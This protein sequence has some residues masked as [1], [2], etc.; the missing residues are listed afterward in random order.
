[1]HDEGGV[2][3]SAWRGVCVCVGLEAKRFQFL[4][5]RDK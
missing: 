2:C 4:L 1:M 3:R 5:D